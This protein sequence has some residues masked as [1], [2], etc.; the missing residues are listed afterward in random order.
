MV[1][2]SQKW[3]KLESF[4]IAGIDDIENMPPSHPR[5][6]VYKSCPKFPTLVSWTNNLPIMR[7]SVQT[8]KGFTICHCALVENI[9]AYEHRGHRFKT[10]YRQIHSGSDDH[11]KCQTSLIGS[12]HI[13]SSE[14][15]GRVYMVIV[16]PGSFSSGS[17]S[18]L[19]AWAVL[20]QSE[21]SNSTNVIWPKCPK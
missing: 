16:E 7:E 13:C 19:R 17:V 10:R 18:N 15:Q 1:Q 2:V 9:H 11:L 5:F 8:A 6:T 12:F 21:K 14:L 20:V 4:S 3:P